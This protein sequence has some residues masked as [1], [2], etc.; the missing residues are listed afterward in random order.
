MQ[1]IERCD[2][3]VLV[4]DAVRGITAQDTIAGYIKD[5]WKGVMVVINKW[6]LI[7]K[8]ISQHGV[9]KTSGRS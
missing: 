4:V 7:E 3:A 9:R 2:A 8:T 6:D 1:T 5:A